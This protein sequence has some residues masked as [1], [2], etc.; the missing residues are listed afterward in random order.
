MD[1]SAAT[2]A[3]GVLTNWEAIKKAEKTGKAEKPKRGEQASLLDG[4][5]RS[6][7]ALLEATKLGSEAAKTGFDWPDRTGLLEKIEEECREVDAEVKAGASAEA[8][9]GELGDLL[10]TVVNLARHL[11]VDPELAL[12]R[13]NTKFR[14]RFAAMEQACDGALSEQ[15]AAALEALWAQAKQREAVAAE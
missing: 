9:E 6:F 10:F 7:P 1:A 8:V 15:S 12:K 5:P 11:R 4:V 14:T 2:E 3:A 13:T